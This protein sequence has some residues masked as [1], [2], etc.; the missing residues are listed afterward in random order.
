[1]P[2]TKMIYFTW[3]VDQNGY[4]LIPETSRTLACIVGKGGSKKP[5]RPLDE[6]P[7]L[8]RV[9]SKIQKT[10]EGVLDFI[11]KFGPLTHSGFAGG[12]GEKVAD[13]IDWATIMKKRLEPV[14]G[15]QEDIPLNNLGAHLVADSEGPRLEFRPSTLIDALWLQLGQELS[16]GTEILRCLHC[17]ELF[18]A[19]PGTSR[20]A[21]AMFCLDEHRIE[22]NSLKRSR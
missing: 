6:F 10:S 9:F 2:A 5:Y 14:E 7:T 11:E 17:G 18:R 16:G 20:R 21:D 4:D 15:K 3:H 19:G 1:M 8:F 12:K 13:V 22:F